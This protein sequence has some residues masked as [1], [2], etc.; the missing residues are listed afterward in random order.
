MMK[1]EAAETGISRPKRQ[2][3]A[4]KKNKKSW[5]KNTD[6]E[7]VEEFLDDQR[8][9][10]RLGGAFDKRKDSDIFVLDKSTNGEIP[11]KLSKYGFDQCRLKSAP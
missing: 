6:V 3:G 9:E 10:E 7:E 5:R 8:L 1:V 11:G 2:K 4:S